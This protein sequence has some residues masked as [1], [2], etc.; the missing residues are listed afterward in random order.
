[1][2]T[3][4]LVESDILYEN[5]T[6]WVLAVGS[7]WTFA[8]RMYHTW[9]EVNKSEAR[10]AMAESAATTQ[11]GQAPELRPEPSLATKPAS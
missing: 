8:H 9:R 7:Y 10:E 11:A 2:A 5:P 1:M 6:H 4:S 3:R